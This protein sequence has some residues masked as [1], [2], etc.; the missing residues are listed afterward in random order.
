MGAGPELSALGLGCNNF[1][2]RLDANQ[3]E[4]VVAASLDVGINHFDT[5]DIYGDGLSEQ[6]L[7]RAIRGKRA[8]VVISTK[9]G[10]AA[11]PSLV[12]VPVST[13][14]DRAMPAFAVSGPTTSTCTTCTGLTQ[15]RR[16][17]KRSERSRNWWRQGRCAT[18]PAPT[19][20]RGK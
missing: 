15:G 10:S 13:W 20:S 4:A 1:G 14:L 2:P 5:A 16:S 8:D 6:Y 7:G 3:S 11:T 9:V 17:A 12:A 18:S 19:T